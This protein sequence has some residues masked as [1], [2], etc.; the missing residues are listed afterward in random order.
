MSFAWASGD[1]E[2]FPEHRE[3][4]PSQ[5]TDRDRDAGGR[6]V[7]RCL[8]CTWTGGAVAALEHH[9]NTCHHRIQMV[10]GPV[11]LFR[12]CQTVAQPKER[13]A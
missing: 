2:S 8:D 3:L 10:N 7:Y 6:H 5:A 12:C 11:Q 4:F 9:V 13:S 1:G